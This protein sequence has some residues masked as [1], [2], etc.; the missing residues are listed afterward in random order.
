MI[1]SRFSGF[2]K[3]LALSFTLALVAGGAAGARG[4][5]GGGFSVSRQPMPAVRDHRGGMGGGVTVSDIPNRFGAATRN[6]VF[7]DHRACPISP[8]APY[9]GGT[10]KTCL[11]KAAEH[12]GEHGTIHARPALH[13]ALQRAALFRGGSV[14]RD[15]KKRS[16]STER[17]VPYRRHRRAPMKKAAVLGPRPRTTAAS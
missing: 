11:R 1:H 10:D 2:A 4:G 17:A 7:R 3:T 15:Y 5:F 8:A 9:T 14:I 12:G 6:P 13:S 16:C